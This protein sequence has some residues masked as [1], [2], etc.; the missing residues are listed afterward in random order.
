M[1]VNLIV[2]PCPPLL[3][4]ATTISTGAPIAALTEEEFPDALD[5]L[6]ES[7][8]H[9]DSDQITGKKYCFRSFSIRIMITSPSLHGA[10][11]A[12]SVNCL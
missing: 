8:S 3:L 10:A 1:T 12:E 6:S 9:S 5:F 7:E 2:I 11:Q 4:P